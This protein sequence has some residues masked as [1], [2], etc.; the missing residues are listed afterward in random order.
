MLE[1]SSLYFLRDNVL[2]YVNYQKVIFL[3]YKFHLHF[4]NDLE[5]NIIFVLKHVI[6]LS[7]N[8]S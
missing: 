3:C 2:S 6:L 1:K 7:N 8:S 4:G 5:V